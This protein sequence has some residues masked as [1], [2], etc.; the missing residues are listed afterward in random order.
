MVEFRLIA[1]R[2]CC[3]VQ[4]VH[5]TGAEGIVLDYSSHGAFRV[6]DVKHYLDTRGGVRTIVTRDV[7]VHPESIEFC[8]ADT[9]W[10]ALKDL[11]AT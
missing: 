5:P 7:A 1:Y 3:V 2:Q 4:R 8:V 6:L 11:K 9:P 10:A